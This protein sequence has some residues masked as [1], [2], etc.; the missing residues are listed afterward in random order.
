VKFLTRI[1]FLVVPSWAH[2]D[3]VSRRVVSASVRLVYIRGSC[4][5]SHYRF[6]HLV[7]GV[8]ENPLDFDQFRL[9]I[10]LSPL[11]YSL[12]CD[13]ALNIRRETKYAA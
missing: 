5:S 7:A 9:M 8:L 11:T 12:I 2:Q 4:P 1:G 6:G 10:R 13:A 3:N